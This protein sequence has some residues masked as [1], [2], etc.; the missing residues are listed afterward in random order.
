M[1]H[2]IFKY[3]I[4]LKLGT[5]NVEMPATQPILSYQVQEGCHR[6]N[7]INYDSFCMYSIAWGQT[8]NRR[9]H[10]VFTGDD[11]DPDWTF[12]GTVKNL[13]YVYH[14]FEQV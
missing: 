8:C 5:H 9:F 10:I 6:I 1:P 7:H 11:V 4:P 2:N 13:G 14:I 12:V 3:V